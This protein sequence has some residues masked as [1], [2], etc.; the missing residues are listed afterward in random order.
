MGYKKGDYYIWCPRCDRRIYRSQ[1]VWD[2]F[3]PNMLVCREC[4]DPPWR[5]DPPP[6]DKILV[7]NPQPEPEYQELDSQ[8]T[9]DDL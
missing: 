2:G 7:D 3:A 4:Y 5:T 6:P 9:R 1:A 8:I